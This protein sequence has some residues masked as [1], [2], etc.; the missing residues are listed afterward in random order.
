MSRATWAPPGDASTIDPGALGDILADVHH[1]KLIQ[2]GDGK[3]DDRSVVYLAPEFK[4]G[5]PGKN[6]DVTLDVGETTMIVA[7]AA[8]Q[9]KMAIPGVAFGWASKNE[10][11]VTVDDGMIEAVGTGKSEITAT[12]MGRGIAV[13]FTVNVLSEV[14]S[15]V[16]DSP[17]DGFFLTNGESVALE[18]TAYDTALDDGEVPD[19][20]KKVEVESITF[21][22]SDTDVIMIDGKKAKAVGVGTAT[23]TARYADI[24]SKG[25]MINV[26]PG[27]DTTHLLTYT[28]IGAADRMFHIAKSHDYD[29]SGSTGDIAVFGPGDTRPT[30]DDLPSGGTGGGN[31]EYTVQV[32]Q[33]DSEG[34]AND[35]ASATAGENGLRVKMVQGSS[36]DAVGVGVTINAGIATV[37]V[38]N[39]DGGVGYVTDTMNL[40]TAA[41][42]NAVV[43]AG[44]SRIIL[45]YP[46]ADDI[47]LPAITVTENTEDE[48]E[49]DS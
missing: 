49:D 48:P 11:A 22:S 18:A 39:D 19:S 6:W 40:V 27:G 30:G 34:N 41:D 38:N 7:K 20:A 33:Y 36:I 25:I 5:K 21:M 23:I 1:I 44:V 15:V 8:T 3:P 4:M 16:I 47:A 10:D 28:R 29:G 9:T 17:D 35:D 13:K 32:R 26:T 42:T 43:K 45:S 37:T 12:A 2:D 46:G 31:V 24:K 14:K